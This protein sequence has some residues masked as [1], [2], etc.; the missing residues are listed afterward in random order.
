MRIAAYDLGSNSFHMVVADVHTDG[1]F[2]I[3]V[4]EKD[5]LR[6]GDVVSRHGMLTEESATRAEESMRRMRALANAVGA[7]E[8]VACA[9]SALREASNGPEVV[10]RLERASGVTVRVIDGRDEAKL[11]F[12]AIRA[13]VAIDPAPALCLDLGGGSLEMAVGDHAGLQWCTSLRLGVARL[14]TQ[15]TLSEKP[16]KAE[17]QRLRGRI[18][19]A[20]ASVRQSVEDLIPRLLIVTSGTFCDLVR[21]T[22]I[23]RSGTE[24][25]SLNNARVT[26]SEL[27]GMHKRL[28]SMN[29]A[30]RAL[31]PGIDAKRGDVMV[32]GS[33][34]LLTAMD[35]FGLDEVIAGEWALREGMVLDAIG[36][37]DPADYSGDPEAVR[38]S[39]VLSLARRCHW[40]AS[41][42]RHVAS[43]ALSLFDQTQMVHRL[44]PADRELLEYS[45]LL[46]DIG[47][48]VSADAHHKHTSYLVQHGDLR[49]FTPDES[50]ALAALSRYHR[51]SDPK[52][53]HEPFNRLSPD[54]QARVTALAALL[55]IADGLDRGHAGAVSAVQATIEDRVVHLAINA[56]VMTGA[57]LEVWGSRRKRELF[58]KTFGHTLEIHEL[59]PEHEHVDGPKPH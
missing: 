27:E 49:G 55:R 1:T 5:M 48:H 25:V 51:G 16:T 43:L 56:A 44:G 7:D 37:H 38:R 35:V 32:F 2:H 10:S 22:V 59:D 11:I 34:M 57:Q 14:S 40:N 50:N 8:H 53:T 19:E 41:H 46:H 58:E 12:N 15:V 17:L 30:E 26:L 52:Q 9:T 39:S 42:S 54:L 21:A 47:E 6:L 36:H 28:I 20:I 23:R 13:S 29:P 31:V 18:L 33:T 24:P 3:V 4:R 45:A